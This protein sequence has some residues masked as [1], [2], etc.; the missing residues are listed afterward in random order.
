MA[1][2]D[3]DSLATFRAFAGSEQG[4]TS[5]CFVRCMRDAGLLDDRF[6]AADAD[7]IFAGCKALGKRRIEPRTFYEALRQVSIY[8]GMLSDQVVA[9]VRAARPALRKNSP[10]RRRSKSPR[11]RQVACRSKGSGVP[12]AQKTARSNQTKTLTQRP[13]R[14]GN[15]CSRLS[16]DGSYH[17]LGRLGRL[18]AAAP[19]A[20]CI[21]QRWPL[22]GHI[23]IDPEVIRR[24]ALQR[25]P[26]QRSV[27][28]R[29]SCALE[30]CSEKGR[31][32]LRLGRPEA[33]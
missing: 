21:E 9:R 11:R 16:R 10:P 15:E 27:D 7:L 1:A 17:T 31:R 26:W 18:S 29:P 23:F 12:C 8:K 32:I 19:I 14:V 20:C 30:R 24:Q 5:S 2:F 28:E 6:R 3:S 13:L 25:Q 22:D 33:C 4:M